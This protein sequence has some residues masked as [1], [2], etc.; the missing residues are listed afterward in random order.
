[1]V[2]GLQGGE[3][4]FNLPLANAGANALPGLPS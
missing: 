2:Q 1:M 3:I 4:S